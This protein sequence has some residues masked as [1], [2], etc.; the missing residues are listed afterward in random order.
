M[1]AGNLG[2]LCLVV[3]FFIIRNLLFYTFLLAF[4]GCNNWL[5]YKMK[6]KKILSDLVLLVFFFLFCSTISYLLLS[7]FSLSLRFVFRCRFSFFKV[8]I[9]LL[10]DFSGGFSGFRDLRDFEAKGGE[11]LTNLL[12]VLVFNQGYYDFPGYWKCKKIRFIGIFIFQRIEFCCNLNSKILKLK[13]SQA[14]W[15]IC[16]YFFNIIQSLINISRFESISI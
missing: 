8:V 12:R 15:Y 2:N 5:N 16:F 10:C 3:T 7:V 13:F 6:S 11:V 4:A 9:G 1:F 14:W